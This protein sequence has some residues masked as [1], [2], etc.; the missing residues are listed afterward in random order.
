MQSRGWPWLELNFLE[1]YHYFMEDCFFFFGEENFIKKRNQRTNQ[2]TAKPQ[3]P[4][5]LMRTGKTINNRIFSR[6]EGGKEIQFCGQ[7]PL[8]TKEATWSAALLAFLLDH[9]QLICRVEA[10]HRA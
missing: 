8:K 2:K 1:N 9:I 5:N 4:S 10:R 6:E 3:P 7:A